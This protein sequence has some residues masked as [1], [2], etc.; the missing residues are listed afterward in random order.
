MIERN[1][2]TVPEIIAEAG[3]NHDGLVTRALRLIDIGQAAG[4]SSV[5]FQFIF[6]DGLYLPVF[7]DGDQL[8]PNPAHSQRRTEQLTTQEW[9]EVWRYGQR[10]GIGLS[11]SVFCERGLDL[12]TQ[13]GAEYVKIASTDLTNFDLI[14]LAAAR[15]NRVLLSTGMA[16][17]AEVSQT[18]TMVQVRHPNVRL[19]L[20]HCVSSYPCPAEDANPKRVRLLRDAFGLRV[21]YSDHTEGNLSAI[22]ALC[23]GAN[24]FEKH[25]TDDRSLAGFD[26]ANAMEPNQLRSYIDDIHQAAASLSGNANRTAVREE[27]T[28]VRA[29]RGVYAAHDLAAG[30]ILARED[31]LHVRP[32]TAQP[33]LPSQLIGRPLAFD[34]RRYDALGDGN[35]VESIVSRWHE[36]SDYWAGEMDSKGMSPPFEDPGTCE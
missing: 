7:R 29:R 35:G 12:L 33:T 22:L 15:F 25:F 28:K 16:T 18:V 19:E 6:P 36:A 27:E 3:S 10:V 26:H 21:G 1:K 4:A 30:H 13:L 17:L 8:H 14:D 34:V 20:L 23:Q 31:L 11:A 24:L 9:E 5:K 32:S 2:F